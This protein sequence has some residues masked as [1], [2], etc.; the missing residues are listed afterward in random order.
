[1]VAYYLEISGIT[2]ASTVALTNGVQ[3][4]QASAIRVS[5]RKLVLLRHIQK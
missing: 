1:M 2:A 4:L 3:T 5:P